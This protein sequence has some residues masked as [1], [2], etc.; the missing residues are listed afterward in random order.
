M[1]LTIAPSTSLSGGSRL[2]GDGEL[3][4]LVCAR[5]SAG[6]KQSSFRRRAGRTHLCDHQHRLASPTRCSIST[7]I[8]CVTNFNELGLKGLA[9]HPGYRDQS[10]VFL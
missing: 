1:F 3:W 7:S 6:R 9:F 10:R 5:I 2:P 8:R 4:R